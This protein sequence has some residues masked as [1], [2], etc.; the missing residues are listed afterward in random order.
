MGLPAKYHNTAYRSSVGSQGA[1]S[2]IMGLQLEG[3]NIFAASQPAVPP[4]EHIFLYFL[5]Y[6]CFCQAA[7]TESSSDAALQ[8]QSAKQST[9]NRSLAAFHRS[10]SASQCSTSGSTSTG[11]HMRTSLQSNHRGLP[12][13]E[14]QPPVA[15]SCRPSPWQR[16]NTAGSSSHI[17][18][19]LAPDLWTPTASQAPLHAGMTFPYSCTQH[20]AARQLI[21]PAL[22]H[23]NST[24]VTHPLQPK[25]KLHILCV[26]KHTL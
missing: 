1:D 2:A 8:P 24:C 4:C 18:T 17:L 20:I 5:T 7:C 26:L 14:A 15:S 25:D 22:L 11:F 10:N 19:A 16:L 21:N 23:L 13:H 3:A 9:S 6:S 12:V